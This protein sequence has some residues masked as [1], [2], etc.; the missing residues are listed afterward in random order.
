MRKKMK[1]EHLAS[2]EYNYQCILES[3]HKGDHR[4]MINGKEVYLSGCCPEGQ[5]K[6]YEK[7]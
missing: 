4:Y 6:S 3:R 1:C 2:R 5:I 7:Q